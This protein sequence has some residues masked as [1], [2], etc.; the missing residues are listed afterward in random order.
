MQVEP[1]GSLSLVVVMGCRFDMLLA[2]TP[3]GSTPSAV[4]CNRVRPL[5]PDTRPTITR[6]PYLVVATPTGVTVR[7]RS[8]HVLV[9]QA[10]VGRLV[11]GGGVSWLPGAVFTSIR[12]PG[13]DQEV[14]LT[15]L[16]P[17]R[18]YVYQVRHLAGVVPDVTVLAAST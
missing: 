14:P 12:C 2:L 7:W 3:S 13:L 5:P 4:P 16:V 18:E 6:G 15:G 9:G 8:S 10:R 1:H 11:E 17:G